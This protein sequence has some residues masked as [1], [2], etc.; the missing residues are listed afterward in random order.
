MANKMLGIFILIATIVAQANAAQKH[1]IYWKYGKKYDHVPL[2][3]FNTFEIGDTL[4]K[5]P[6]SKKRFISDFFLTANLDH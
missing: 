2:Q 6:Y 4:G 1:E 3:S 5:Y